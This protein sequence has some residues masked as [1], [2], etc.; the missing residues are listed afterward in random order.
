MRIAFVTPEYVTEEN[1][2]G[3]LSNYLHRVAVA[4]VSMGHCPIV[5]VSSKYNEKFEIDGVRIFRVNTQ[6][7]WIENYKDQKYLRKI[8]GINHYLYQS[9]KL[10]YCLKEIHYIEPIE[11]VQYTH[12]EGV[13]LFKPSFIPSVV[14]F[15]SATSLFLKSSQI[16]GRIIQKLV[17]KQALRGVDG[18]FCPS[19]IIADIVKHETGKHVIVI[20]SPYFM[21]TKEWNEEIYQRLMQG[22][23]YLLFFGTLGILKGVQDIADILWGVLQEHPDLYFLFVGKDIG[24][25]DGRPMKDYIYN[26]VGDF[27]DRVCF[28]P[29]LPHSSLYPLIKYALAVVLPSHFDNLPNACIEAMGL[30]RVVVGTRGTSFEQL[31]DDGIDGFLCKAN[32]PSDLKRA[33]VKAVNLS[34][35]DRDI[36]EENAVK[37]T[38]RLRPEITIQ[39]LL[40]YYQ[41][42]LLLKKPMGN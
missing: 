24:Q 2:D 23:R 14:R 28:L 27:R 12:L 10:N 19:N 40:E 31:I 6:L 32:D 13:G 9:W 37:K 29:R 33:V 5:I 36:I 3:G 18:I 4:L 42:I 20:E 30:G 26:K 15:S 22:K 25:P 8:Y 7:P 34:N 38:E 39:H 41:E 21:E 17:E 16:K 11:I 35:I 1:F